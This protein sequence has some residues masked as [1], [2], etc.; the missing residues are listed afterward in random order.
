MKAIEA[1]DFGYE[2]VTSAICC[3]VVNSSEGFEVINS[4]DECCLAD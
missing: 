2:P 3:S 4:S 1:Y